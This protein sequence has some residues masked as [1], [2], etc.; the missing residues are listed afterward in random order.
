MH[1]SV[2]TGSQGRLLRT[3]LLAFILCALT[4][5][6]FSVCL[7]AGTDGRLTVEE[8]ADGYLRSIQAGDYPAALE[9]AYVLRDS[10]SACEDM[11]LRMLADS[12]VGQAFL[13]MDE[14]DSAYHYL[15]ESIGI[16]NGAERPRDAES[17]VTA[18]YAAFN[19]LA[20]YSIVKDMNYERA[21]EYLLEGMQLA[22]ERNS[23]Y[24]YGVLGSNLVYTYNLRQDTSGLSIAREIYR[25]GRTSENKYLIFTGSSTSA[26]M[27]YLKGDLDSAYKYGKEAVQLAVHY[28]DQAGVYALYG[29]IL[30]DMGM[31][32][33]AETYYLKA[34]GA[35][36]DASSSTTIS[37]YLSYG[38]FLVD[39][40]RYMEAVGILDKGVRLSD[41]T[42]NRIFKYRLYLG[43]S[44]A[45]DRMGMYGKALEMYRLYH[46]N[47]Q[48][49][50]DIQRERTLNE[51]ARKYEQEKHAREIQQHTLTI[52]RKDK[53]LLTAVFVILLILAVLGMT[54][55]M[56][57]HKNRMYAR[58]VRQYKDALDK[59]KAMNRKIEALEERLRS[60]HQD[61][62]TVTSDKVED[63]LDRLEVL[64]K[65]DKV[66]R[67]KS[68]TRDRVAAMLGT[69]RTYLS[70]VIN[71]KTGMSFI[72]Y[73]NSYRIEEA[74][75]VL[76]DPGNEIPLK[77]L[78][79]D[80]GF[81]SLTTFYTFF[82]KKVG[83]TPAKY[84]EEVRRLSNSTNC[85]TR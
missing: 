11:S 80:L 69:N 56:Y 8:L 72:H 40:G 82:S 32:R 23:Y 22:E 25:Y 37:M 66:Y 49:V 60:S 4:P 43:L 71:E 7:Y 12:Y 39:A 24:H 48:E 14:Y 46:V 77:A 50:L 70:Q 63:L 73:I 67:E 36:G 10:S 55:I 58:I 75:E 74:L 27:F 19:G 53:A 1:R 5:R 83:M 44:D 29:D 81:S 2:S 61:T 17:R 85:R 35:A 45:Y 76:S 52:V 16:W 3:A 65:K 79:L 42:D 15:N 13:A 33:E 78:S 41:S 9:Y 34:M 20:I 26:M 31:D 64:M 30:H 47:S 18:A 51:L 38:S 62:P 21:M 54:Y 6:A 28:S 59:E 57:R 84:R 68:L